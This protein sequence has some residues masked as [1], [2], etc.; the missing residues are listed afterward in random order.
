MK[1]D[2]LIDEARSFDSG[3]TPE[4]EG[5][6]LASTLRRHEARIARGRFA[7]RAVGLASATAIIT[8]FFLRTSSASSHTDAPA[9][10]AA[11]ELA[12]GDGGYG[13]D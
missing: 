10:V 3:W 7:R 13:R 9:V 6:V 1:L 5:R 11:E 12:N 8:F 2:R 4:R